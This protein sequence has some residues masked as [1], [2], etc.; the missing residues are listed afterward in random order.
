MKKQEMMNMEI[1]Q[2]CETKRVAGAAFCAACGA[3]TFSDAPTPASAGA[4]GPALV[5]EPAA[6]Y[7]PTITKAVIA[8]LCA[9]LVATM[10]FGWF[11]FPSFFTGMH[12][13]SAVSGLAEQQ[14]II[15]LLFSRGDVD[16]R[17][18]S[19]LRASITVFRVVW[20]AIAL[21][22]LGIAAFLCLVL[23]ESK[24][25]GRVGQTSALIAAASTLVFIVYVLVW[26][27]DLICM[28]TH[29]PIW[30][31]TPSLWAYLSFLLSLA[32]FFVITKN[33]KNLV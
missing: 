21:S 13:E 17:N 15:S 33:Q 7:K 1:C 10:M 23:T 5:A 24:K 30:F 29:Q 8:A 28:I 6:M 20:V 26:H 12:I 22:S 25:A 16:S 27:Q 14:W 11:S 18:L 31:Q 32:A 2:K 19:I 3:D 9:L 4:T